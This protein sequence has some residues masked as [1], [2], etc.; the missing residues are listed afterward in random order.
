MPRAWTFATT[1]ELSLAH[2]YRAPAIEE[3]YNSGAHDG[4]LTF[5]IGNPALKPETNDG[6][7]IALRQQSK[8]I[9]ADAN[10]YY[11]DLKDYVFLA[12]TGL[13][14]PDSGFPIAR[15]LQGTSRFW[16]LELQGQAKLSK[17]V[18][19]LAGADYVQA[20]LTDGRAL[21]R[22]PPLR[23]RLSLDIHYNSFSLKPE[24]VAV[25]KQA[26]TFTG[27][28]STAGY[29]VVNLSASYVIVQ[30]HLAHLFSVN[31]FN[32]NN[33]LYFNHVSFIKDISPEMGRGI[34]VSYTVRY[35]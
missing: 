25:A 9:K 15:Y 8:R 1:F 18:D 2:S 26:R 11:Y 21:P 20:E 34:K 32:L 19:L 24:F 3:L 31:A 29:G 12:P 17:F 14:D 27:E 16:G 10:F 5:E 28:T 4:T 22:I 30:K 6:I 7:D 23:G 35:F 13:V 33:K